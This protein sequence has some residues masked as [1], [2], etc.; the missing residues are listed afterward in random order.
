MHNVDQIVALTEYFVNFGATLTEG[1]FK[2]ELD[3]GSNDLGMWL[4]A[5][6]ED[7]L[8]RDDLIET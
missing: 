7:I 3:A 5:D 1:T 8:S 4:V 2:R 6:L